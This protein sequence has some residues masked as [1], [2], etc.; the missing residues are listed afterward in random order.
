M[1]RCA[2]ADVQTG[3]PSSNKSFVQAIPAAD[4]G[5]SMQDLFTLDAGAGTGERGHGAGD[6]VVPHTRQA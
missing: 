1:T 6:G 2:A 5:R 4:A 3:Q